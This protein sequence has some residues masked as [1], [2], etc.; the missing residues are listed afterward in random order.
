MAKEEKEEGKY[1]T[2][3]NMQQSKSKLWKK[4]R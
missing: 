3:G 2:E 1:H 4:K